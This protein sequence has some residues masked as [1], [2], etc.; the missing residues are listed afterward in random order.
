MKANYW[1][2]SK[3]ADWVRGTPKIPS[4]TMEE[5]REWKKKARVKKI[6]YWLAEEGLEYLQDFLCWP[7]NRIKDVRRYIQNRWMTKS[8]ALTSNLK[9]GEWHDLDSRL[10]NAIFDELVNFVEIEQA[11]MMVVFSEDDRKKYKTPWYRSLFRIGVW[12]CP[13]AGIS[14]LEWAAALTHNEDWVSK[15]DPIYEQPTPQA[16][17]AQEILTIYRWWK[18]ERPKRP[19]PS[20]ASGWSAYCEEERKDTDTDEDDFLN[21]GKFRSDEDRERSKNILD[22]LAKIEK[23]QHDEDTEMLIRLVKIRQSLWT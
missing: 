21:L 17:A 5:W 1:S 11:W 3:F 8:H 10:L 23:E 2:C 14:H 20:D 18:E 15:D 16:L 7:V 22:I 12:R 4:G 19:V 6:R 9:R 13:E